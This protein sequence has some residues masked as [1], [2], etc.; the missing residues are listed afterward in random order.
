MSKIVEY[1]QQNQEIK[2]IPDILQEYNIK[3]S[4][5]E[6]FITG[7]EFT[8]KKTDYQLALAPGREIPFPHKNKQVVVFHSDAAPERL[9]QIHQNYYDDNYQNRTFLRNPYWW[10]ADNDRVCLER[11]D[12]KE[13][14]VKLNDVLC[15]V[16]VRN[17]ELRLPYFLQ[18]YRNK[19]VAKFF[20]VDNHSTDTTL[21]FLQQQPD[22]YV[23]HTTRSF[24]ISS[25]GLD[26]LELLL[27]NYGVNHWCLTLDADEFL[28]YYDC[29]NKTI[30]QLCAELEKENKQA[31]KAILLDMYSQQPLKDAKYNP[32]QNPLEVCP[33]F[34]K[35]FYTV[36]KLDIDGKMGYWGG[37]RERVFPQRKRM[38]LLHK[39]PLIKYDFHAK[40]SY[41][42][43]S[44]DNLEISQQT[45]CLFHFKYFSNFHD[46][47]KLESAR[48]EYALG[49]LK[50]KMFAIKLDENPELSMY[51]PE[52]SVK[53]K[54]SHQLLELGIIQGKDNNLKDSQC[55]FIIA[56]GR[57]G[58]TLLM[59][60][61]NSIEGYNICGENKGAL[62]QLH[63]FYEQL[64]YT[65]V[66]GK[67]I[68]TKKENK[69]A[70]DNR[71]LTY[72]ESLAKPESNKNSTGV[73]WYNVFEFKAIQEKL[74]ELIVTMFN[75]KGKYQVWG[76]K[77]ILY[78]EKTYEE[79]E[80]E[81]NFLKELFPL[82]K[83]IFN[84]RN[85]EETIKSAWY[86]DNPEASKKILET[87]YQYYLKYQSKYPEFTYHVTYEDLVNNTE[88]LQG[89]YQFLG[90][91]FELDKYQEV[92][93]RLVF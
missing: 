72:E 9:E 45:G 50:Y 31:L 6:Q 42:Q 46:T 26:W 4:H 21:T 5:C 28:Y 18:Y 90:A 84:I 38:N 60:L 74:R 91:E 66:I 49:S 81:L 59:R 10:E 82:T 24:R 89:M 1:L 83:F 62:Q 48:G 93:A 55:V 14:E 87:K 29:E 30:P 41:G 19:G 27:Q 23:W 35:Q 8:Y 73:E 53:F 47:A 67:T 17:E 51:S 13:I 63:K 25:G 57:S 16:V 36:K 80:N 20:I 37:V 71:F 2:S 52:H 79:F 33:Y 40:L 88:N 65:I 39:V 56:Q 12:N 7:G 75:P 76:C 61:L 68:K 44:I 43:H 34:D 11:I 85:I 32:G 70:A 54:D 58:S 3:P 86:A 22:V 77:D 92:L 64:I 15:F 78:G 69:L